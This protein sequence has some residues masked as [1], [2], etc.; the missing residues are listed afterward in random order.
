MRGC[1]KVRLKAEPVVTKRIDCNLKHRLDVLGLHVRL[2]GVRCHRAPEVETLDVFE[3][4]D[5]VHGG[6]PDV[7]TTPKQT[8]Q[9]LWEV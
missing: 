7:E 9:I 5:L 6:S 1:M 8:K 3:G 2:R 4:R